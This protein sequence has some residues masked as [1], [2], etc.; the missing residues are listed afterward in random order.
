MAR[1]LRVCDA[2]ALCHDLKLFTKPK[3]FASQAVSLKGDRE[4]FLS[5]GCVMP[6]LAN[7]HRQKDKSDRDEAPSTIAPS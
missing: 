6:S 7:V 1:F 3:S 2:P 4:A 5:C